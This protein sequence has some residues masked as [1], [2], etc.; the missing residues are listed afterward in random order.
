MTLFIDSLL[1]VSITMVA[2]AGLLVTYGLLRIVNLAHGEMIAVGAYAA[3]VASSTEAGFFVGCA[4]G[5]LLGGFLG[6]LLERV[7]VR[8][9]YG[10]NIAL[11][12]LGTWGI[13]LGLVQILR[14]VFGPVGRFVPVPL[15]GTI[16]FATA[17]YPAYRVIVL[18]I[19][20]F[21]LITLIMAIRSRIGLYIRAAMENQ[22]K[23][24]SYGI[25]TKRTFQLTFIIGSGLAGLSGAL[26]SPIVAIYPGMGTEYTI[27]G[28]LA[29][30]L[31]GSHGINA[32]VFACI[33]LSL[34][35]SLV[36][37][38]VDANAATLA[39]YGASLLALL[40]FSWIDGKLHDNHRLRTWKE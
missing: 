7:V 8:R 9:F 29:L 19:S 12:L 27:L 10:Q 15:E 11:S 5:F 34:C 4:Y 14:L 21:I 17:D 22:N 18:G 6:A 24:E 28:F 23:A 20:I 35:R 31:A 1:A 32:A 38:I 25:N 16:T 3:S 39:M 36:A 37:G 33:L 2:L 40:G 13:S 26:I 30:L